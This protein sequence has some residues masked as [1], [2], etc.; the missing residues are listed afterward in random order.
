SLDRLI[1]EDLNAAHEA[2]SPVEIV[3]LERFRMAQYLIISAEPEDDSIARMQ[4]WAKQNGLES[5]AMIG[6]DVPKLTVEQQTVYG[7]RGYMSAVV[8]PESFTGKCQ[9]VREAW[10]ETGK[11]AHITVREPMKAPFVLIPNAYK[12]IQK[13][14]EDNAIRH[15]CIEGQLSCFEYVHVIDGTEYMD[16]YIAVDMLT[17][18]GETVTL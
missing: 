6:C 8:L 2:F 14:I 5:A 17:P 12:A 11:Y 1:R 13:H 4:K 3:K 18:G 7:L 15:A 10:Q 9:G 16:I